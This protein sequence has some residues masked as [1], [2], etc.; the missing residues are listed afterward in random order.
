VEPPYLTDEQLL[1]WMNRSRWIYARS[2]PKHPH[3]YTLRREQQ[4]DELFKRVCRAIWDC[5]YDRSYL[6][7]PWRSLDIGDHFVWLH[8]KPTS[9]RQPVPLENTILINRAERVQERLI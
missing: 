3:E 7:R 4:D 2:M 8:T 5:G 1:K 6:R 9:P